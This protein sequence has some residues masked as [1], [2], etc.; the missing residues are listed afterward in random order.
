MS[1]VPMHDPMARGV[2]SLRRGSLQTDC[3]QGTHML[4]TLGDSKM[5]QCLPL[6]VLTFQ[7]RRGEL[8]ELLHA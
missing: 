5:N 6:R 1:H 7:I 2:E 3:V 4:G 8:R